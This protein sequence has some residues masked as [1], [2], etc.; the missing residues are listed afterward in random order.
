MRWRASVV[1]RSA[2]AD[3][4]PASIA[5]IELQSARMRLLTPL[6][7]DAEAQSEYRLRNRERFERYGGS[8]PANTLK[9]SHR[10][11]LATAQHILRWNHQAL[12]FLFFR[13]SDSQYIGACHFSGF[14][15]G[16]F[17]SC[18][19]GYHIDGSVEGQGYM[20]EAAIAALDY[21]FNVWGIRRVVAN[22]D[23]QN[24]RSSGLL[25]R[26]GFKVEG[27][28]REWIEVD[29]TRRDAITT[30]LLRSDWE[31]RKLAEV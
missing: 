12:T 20:K 23:E 4:H 1:R 16:P 27:C 15:W 6:A 9:S 17:R 8:L 14:V 13:K 21:I 28:A 11:K 22:Y 30:A 5:P 19:F 25:E 26:L 10:E 3:E 31:R 29:N 7:I 24:L 18:N 2:I